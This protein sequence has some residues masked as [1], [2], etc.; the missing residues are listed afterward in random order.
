MNFS[1]FTAMGIHYMYYSLEY[2]LS[3]QRNAGYESMELWAAAPHVVM[4][5]EGVEDRA[6]L[7]KK[8]RNSG[9]KLQC[10]TPENCTYPWQFAARGERMIELSYRYFLHGIEL[11]SELECPIM[12][13]NS[14]WGLKD[15]PEEEAW[16]RGV[17]MIARLAEKAE[18][19]GV[20]L[21]F[22]SLRPEETNLAYNLARTK[23]FM[24]DTGS[25]NLKP[26]ID[27]CAMA[28]AGETIGEWFDA[29]DGKIRHMH[30]VD[31]TPYGHLIPGDGDRDLTAY[32]KEITA[33]NYD[34]ALTQEITDGRYFD[35]PEAADRRAVEVLSQLYRSI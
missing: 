31:G 20:E 25:K 33:R 19:Y 10:I 27:T 30:F 22:E 7:V 29:F 23:K 4:T 34:G 32:I 16:K 18:A 13:V 8:I 1:Q 35:A 17:H 9:M 12:A 28:V 14:G 21:V 26:M 5:P 15:E 24:E 6:E 2:M 11:C 3:M